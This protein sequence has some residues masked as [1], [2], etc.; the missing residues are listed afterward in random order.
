MLVVACSGPGAASPS[1]SGSPASSTRP[2]ALATGGIVEY[3]IPPPATLPPHCYI[4]CLSVLG[5]LAA[6][7]DRTIWFVDGGRGQVGRIGAD[8]KI[9]QFAMPVPLAGGAQTIAAGPDHNMWVLGR[10]SDQTQPDWI[11][12]VSPTGDVTKFPTTSSDPGTESITTGPDGNLWFTEFSPSRIGKLTPSGTVTEYATITPDASP[13]G[14]TAGPDGNLWFA[15]TNRQRVAIGRISPQGQQTDFPLTAGPSDAAPNDVA[16]GPDGNVWFTRWTPG[17]LGHISPSGE[18]VP[19]ALPQGSA[20]NSVVTGPDGNVWFTD[21]GKNAIAR[22][23]VAGSIREFPLPRRVQG[24]NGIT[25]G[26]D[27]RV[28][29][30]EGDHIASIGVKVPEPLFSQPVPL[31]QR[32]MIFS[33]ASPKTITVTNIGDATL[34][35]GT[36]RVAGIDGN[37]FAKSSDTC[38]GK[39]IEPGATCKVTVT[40]SSGGAAGIAQSAFLEFA[41]NA[42]GTPQKIS[43]VALLRSCSLPTSDAVPNQPRQGGWLDTTTGHGRYDPRALFE[44]STNPPGV[45]TTT[46]PVLVGSSSAYFD[47]ATGRWLPVSDGSAVSPDG[48]RYAYTSYDPNSPGPAANLHVVDVATGKDRLLPTQQGFWAVI[49]FGPHG[50]Y[51]DQR[52]EGIGPGLYL[53]DPDTGAISQLFKDGAV[54]VVAGST[55]WIGVFNTADKLPQPPGIGGGSNEIDKRDVSTGATTRWF[56]APGTNVYVSAVVDGSPIVNIWDGTSIKWVIVTA[57]N[58]AQPMDFPF[59]NDAMPYYTGFVP[60]PMGVWVGSPDG[61][62]L[63]TARTGG[64]L[65]SEEPSTPAGPC[66]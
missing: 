1:A 14:I 62:Y 39:S 55:A 54:G 26:G 12:R 49:G 57:P 2:V 66:A 20:P 4:P 33:D 22:I 23:S 30:V 59:T 51:L 36:V 3:A 34:A 47:A 15:E 65:V 7:P 10:G 61:V 31:S 45:R 32:V 52:Y 19:V 48:S 64:I 35:V 58:Q 40:H 11:L 16:P 63:W 27:G 44:M 5:S 41:D 21:S 37:S 24:M 29:F 50:I 17:G 25:V 6:G 60:D 9:A 42:T 18:F 56:Y 8:G 53:V 38:G 13:R 46:E 43:L 28:W